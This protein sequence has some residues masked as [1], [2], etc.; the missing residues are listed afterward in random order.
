ML[1]YIKKNT[2]K[3]PST[4]LNHAVDLKSYAA[5]A[6]VSKLGMKILDLTRYQGSGG[7][8]PIA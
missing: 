1:S 2:M 8:E 6:L 7:E 4:F 3:V 5:I